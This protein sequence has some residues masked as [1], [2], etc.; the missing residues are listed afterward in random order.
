MTRSPRRRDSCALY[1]AGFAVDHYRGMTELVA[2]LPL[3]P[4][5]GLQRASRAGAGALVLLLVAVGLV[6]ALNS[7]SL[8]FGLAF[9]GGVAL[10]A[11]LWLTIRYYYTAIA[12]ALLLM[13]VVRFEPAPPDLAFALIMC[14]SA[15]TGRFRL[16]R[17]PSLLRWIVAL[18]LVVNLASL[19][20]VV[21]TSAA[22]RFLF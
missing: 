11:F 8:S 2:R 10:L 1:S 21:S 6:D 15:V 17:V 7:T 14:V 18:L 3:G 22:V 9:A 12:I 20:D 4:T 16:G 13:G 19:T 5:D